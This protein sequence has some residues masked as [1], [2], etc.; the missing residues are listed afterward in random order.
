[1][2]NYCVTSLNVRTNTSTVGVFSDLAYTKTE[3]S[4]IVSKYKD[5]VVNNP[6]PKPFWSKQQPD[7]EF[8]FKSR[9]GNI[10][11]EMEFYDNGRWFKASIATFPKDG[12]DQPYVL[13]SLKLLDGTSMCFRLL[14]RI[15]LTRSFQYWLVM[16][17]GTQPLILATA[18]GGWE[19]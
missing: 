11:D 5:S 1:M 3:F 13:L 15:V 2:N 19:R 9:S 12:T 14:T 6:R 7:G 4:G 18:Y 17:G 16:K 10:D 8:H